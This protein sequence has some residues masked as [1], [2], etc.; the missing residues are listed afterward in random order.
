MAKLTVGFVVY[1]QAFAIAARENMYRVLRQE[2]PALEDEDGLKIQERWGRSYVKSFDPDDVGGSASWGSRTEARVWRTI[3]EAIAVVLLV[4]DHEGVGQ[5]VV[6]DAQ[7]MQ[8][9]DSP[10]WVPRR[11]S[12]PDS[13][14][15]RLRAKAKG[16]PTVPGSDIGPCRTQ[17]EGPPTPP[18]QRPQRPRRRKRR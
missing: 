12:H 2:P 1:S 16:S 18:K 6:L 10:T 15:S 14:V 9:V 4:S 8:T 17:P 7:T 13:Q 11:P 5:A 3:D